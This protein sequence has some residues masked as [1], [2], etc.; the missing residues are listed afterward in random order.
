MPRPLSAITLPP[1]LPPPMQTLDR[2]DIIALMFDP[3]PSPAFSLEW[4]FDRIDGS[5]S[6]R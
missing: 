2:S 6:K 5:G 1:A 3:E 4:L